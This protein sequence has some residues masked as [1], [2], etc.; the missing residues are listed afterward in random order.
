MQ[1]DFRE[2]AESI[3][4]RLRSILED[5]RIHRCATE[6]HPRKRNGSYRTDGVRGWARNW[7]TGETIAWHEQRMERRKAPPQPLP[8][9]DKRR[10][11]EAAKARWAAGV[12]NYRVKHATMTM[13]PYLGR[14]GFPKAMG[15]VSEGLLLVP[16]RI[17][18]EIVSLQ[19]IA[20]DGTKRNLPGGRMAGASFS[21]GSGRHEIL[22]EGYA[23]GLSIKAALTGLCMPAR[24][25]CCFS[26]ANV[27]TLAERRR[28]ALVVADHDAPVAQLGGI[29]TGAFYARRTGLPWVMPPDVGTDAN[30]FH[31][32]AGLPALQAL[33][34]QLTQRR[35]S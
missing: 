31:L 16:A 30:D 27:A 33:L 8:S 15:L 5:D 34:L 25:T 9:L 4:C 10:E 23:T 11:E 29:G 22:C 7:E 13:H 19:E 18:A 17:G 14:K 28:H 1:R 12:A 24:V 21:I 3:G 35:P 20:A 2:A 32:A 6:L 26:A